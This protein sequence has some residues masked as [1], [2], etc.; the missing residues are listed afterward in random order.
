MS[1]T[2]FTET[3]QQA[4][5]EKWTLPRFVYFPVGTA[6]LAILAL[7][8]P[9]PNDHWA[10]Q[11]LWVSLVT[12]SMF[13]WT[14]CFHETVHQTLCGSR[15]ISIWL[16]RILGTLMFVPYTAYRESHIRH[17]AYLN[18]PADWELW[19][20]SD[21]NTSLRFRRVF[22]WF[23]L[24]VGV[25]MSPAIYSRLYFHPD[26][27]ITNP[28]TRKT[29]RREYIGMILVWAS[30]IGGVIYAGRV[31]TFLMAW[32]LPHYLAGVVQSVRKFTEH[33]GMKDYDPMLGTRTVIGDNW[34]TRFCT[35]LN[36]DIFVHG[37]HHR[38]P[39]VSHDRLIEKM[40]DYMSVN[41][42][43]EYPVF[44][45]YWQAICHMIPSMFK[46][47]G[48]GM[49]LGA[50]EPKKEKS[51]EVNNFVADVT[52]EVLADADVDPMHLSS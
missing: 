31:H 37:P 32:V 49:N 16:G 18:K 52:R 48:V 28:E 47:P 5:E 11:A 29:L 22:V 38:H 35:Y 20:Y 14:S 26:S 19:P 36:F 4:L 43:K 17:H 2:T 44:A 34:L 30:I 12:Y 39:R 40:N 15:A 9:W 33:L 46:N 1:L 3:E 10:W 23:D 45:T 51:S 8:L 50:P 7:D 27:P 25:F 13:C 6:A 42:T 24:I 21:P 41:P